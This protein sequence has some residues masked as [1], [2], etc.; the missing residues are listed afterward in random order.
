MNKRIKN[1]PPVKNKGGYPKFIPSD[2][3]R[4]TV[5]Q[6]TALKV[7]WDEQRLAIINPV[8]NKPLCKK[9]FS[10]IFAEEL[11]AGRTML[12]DVVAKK[13]FQALN[14]GEAWA[15]KLGLRN[16]HGWISEGSQPLPVD[17]NDVAM[18]VQNIGVRFIL[19]PKRPRMRHHRS[20]SRHRRMK[21]S[22][23]ISASQHCQRQAE[24]RSIRR[25]ARHGG[26]RTMTAGRAGCGNCI[27]RHA[28]SRTEK[29]AQWPPFSLEVC[30]KLR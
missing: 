24:S 23:R 17:D 2:E 14:A 22:R 29:A 20:M 16:V 18:V 6:L 5:T 4:R 10:K 21:A 13:Y 9:H 7:S 25:S 19:P 3:Q 12:K 27:A 15:I 26:W 8:S 1:I 30:S 11:K 28:S